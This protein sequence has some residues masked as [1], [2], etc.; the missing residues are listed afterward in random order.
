MRQKLWRATVSITQETAF[1]IQFNDS[2]VHYHLIWAET[3][4]VMKA[5]QNSQNERYFNHIASSASISCTQIFHHK[6]M[7]VYFPGFLSYYGTERVFFVQILL[8][9]YT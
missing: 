3:V 6:Q 8:F 1:S 7:T 9:Q 4:N 2:A 5:P